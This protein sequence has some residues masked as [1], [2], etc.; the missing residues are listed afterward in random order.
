MFIARQEGKSD[1]E[2]FDPIMAQMP[3]FSGTPVAGFGFNWGLAIQIAGWTINGIGLGLST[4]E[5]VKGAKDQSGVEKLEPGEIS[6]IASQIATADPQHRSASQWEAILASQFGGPTAPPPVP[7]GFYT[8]PATGQ[9]VPIPTKQAG[10]FGGLPTWALV[11]GGL[12]IFMVIKG[13]GL[14]I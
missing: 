7:P 2:A 10:L 14:K 4:Y 3:V 13:G 11:G 5:A 12:L 9:L 8:D 1:I 6:A